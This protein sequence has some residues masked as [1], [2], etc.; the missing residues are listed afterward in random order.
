MTLTS[1]W[2][3]MV[4]I[5]VLCGLATGQGE[6]VAAAAV[7]GANAAV[8]LCLSIGGMLCLWT[9]VMEVMRRCGLAD[10]ISRLLQP[11][12]RFLYPSLKREKEIMDSIAANVSANLLGLGNAATPFG[13][14]AARKMSRKSP[15]VASDELCMLVVC[16]TASIQLI[17]TTVAAVRAGA[18]SGAPFDILPAVWLAS[19]L[20]VG[21]GILMCKICAR[22]WRWFA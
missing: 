12:L 20:S 3:G 14:E 4:C 19:G 7:E 15:G 22:V 2:T 5:S 6:Q 17:P 21:A 1:I 18:G 9:G 13:L 11:I 8:E 10:Q 16:N